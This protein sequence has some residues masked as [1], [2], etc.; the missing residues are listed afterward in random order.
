MP[1]RYLFG[2]CYRST[3]S[4]QCWVLHFSTQLVHGNASPAWL[5]LSYCGLLGWLH[6]L[7]SLSCSWV[8]VKMGLAS[9][10]FLL[11]C[12]LYLYVLASLSH[13]DDSMSLELWAK[14]NPFPSQLILDGV[15]HHS[16]SKGTHTHGKSQVW[17]LSSSVDERTNKSASIMAQNNEIP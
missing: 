3:A 17:S 6:L 4:Y 16:H 11:P 10:L 8:R 13:H 15:F 14:M 1:L 5:C 2:D 7:S 9:F 12:L